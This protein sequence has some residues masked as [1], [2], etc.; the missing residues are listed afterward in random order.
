MIE[1]IESILVLIKG[2]VWSPPLLL[3]VL[4]TGTYLTFSL[5]FVQ[6][7]YL[8][9][10]LKQA[11]TAKAEGDKGDINPYEAFMATLAGN[12]GTGNIV[13]VTTALMVG[14]MGSLFW[15]WVT[16][17]ISMAVKYGESVLAIHYRITD[18]AG[19]MCGGPMHYLSA[20]LGWKKMASFY[21]LF[22]ALAAF[23]TGNFVQVN[24][25]AASVHAYVPM[26]PWI[27]GA[28]LSLVTAL[29][30]IGGVKSIGRVSS[31]LVPVMALLYLVSGCLILLVHYAQIPNAFMQILTAAFTPQAAIGG[32]AG[33]SVYMAIQMGVSRSIFSSDAGLGVSSIIAAAAITDNPAKQSLI[34]MTGALISTV[35]V[36]SITGLVVVVTGS[37]GATSP[38]GE[39]LSGVQLATHAFNSTLPGGGVIVAIGLILFAFSTLLAWAYFGEKC[40]E[41]LWGEKA[42]SYFRLVFIMAVIP[43]AALKLE[44]AWLLAD[45]MNGLIVVP[46]LLALL[47]LS[48]VIAKETTTFI[49][50]E[51]KR[52]IWA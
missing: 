41:Y 4:A 32:M 36:C 20:G 17:F 29:V 12:I 7:R 46:N 40:T 34:N 37:L 39:V 16:A 50:K 26:N 43:A 6:F 48:G 15:M 45:I 5:S 8:G 2:W 35:L 3:F 51:E 24:A 11:F 14:G 47:F 30:L 44:I 38:S 1:N 52:K 19:Q 31:V 28:L 33:A 23:G 42:V 49:Q 22:C 18:K 25:I 27:T 9:Y 21:A 13:G 10:A